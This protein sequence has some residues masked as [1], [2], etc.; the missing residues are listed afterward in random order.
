MLTESCK[1][2]VRPSYR[3]TRLAPIAQCLSSAYFEWARA[4][5]RNRETDMRFSFLLI[6]YIRKY[7]LRILKNSLLNQKQN[8]YFIVM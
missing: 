4:K 5:N 1:T 6:F 2:E 8:K 3:T 7:W